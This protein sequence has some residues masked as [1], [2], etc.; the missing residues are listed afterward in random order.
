M[1][2]FVYEGS[3]TAVFAQVETKVFQNSYISLEVPT[4]WDCVREGD[5]FVCQENGLPTV[6]S[7]AVIAAKIAD[8]ETDTP[9]VFASELGLQRTKKALD[10]TTMLSKPID[11]RLRCIRGTRWQWAKQ[12]QSEL[13]NYYTEYFATVTKGI[14]I[15]VSI[16]YHT[17]VEADG[18]EFARLIAR[19]LTVTYGAA[20]PLASLTDKSACKWED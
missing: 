6:S 11:S 4:T 19:R 7:M 15:L 5:A 18:R 13:A 9:A 3:G 16:S 20:N 14:A 8:P 17:S 10:G 1:I 12:Y 2:A